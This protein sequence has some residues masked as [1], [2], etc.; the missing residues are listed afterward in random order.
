MGSNRHM[1]YSNTFSY[2]KIVNLN[3]QILT[4]GMGIGKYWQIYTFF[5]LLSV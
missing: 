1:M 5:G 3:G 2:H 4:Y